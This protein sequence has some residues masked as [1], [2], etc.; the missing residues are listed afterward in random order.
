M[1]PGRTNRG[2]CLQGAYVLLVISCGGG[3]EL[4]CGKH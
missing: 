3:G 1:S 2:Y 4:E